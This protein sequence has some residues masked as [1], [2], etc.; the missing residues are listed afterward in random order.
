MLEFQKNIL[1]FSCLISFCLFSNSAFSTDPYESPY[2]QTTF[3]GI[4]L[5]QMPTARSS[6]EGE[7]LFGFSSEEPYNR[8]FSK[9]QVFPWLEAVVRY[10]EGEFKPYNLGINDQTWKDKGIDFKIRLY[11]EKGIWPELALGITDFGGTGAFASEYIVASKRKSNIDFTLGLGWGRFGGV[12]HLTNFIGYIDDSRKKRGGN[13]F[14]GGTL[15]IERLFSGEQVSVFGGIEYFTPLRNLSL[16]LE[17]DTSNY[18]KIIGVE[19][20]IF[21]KGNTFE[22]DS[23][24]NFAIN[25]RLEPSDR[26][27]IDVSLGL[28]HGNTLYANFAVHSNLNF[29]GS[30]KITL[31][32]EK[33]RNTNLPA[34][35]YQELDS[36]RQKFLTNRIIK[37]MANSGFVTHKVIFRKSELAAEISQSRFLDTVDYIDLASRILANN[38]LENIKTITIINIDQG[39]ETMRSSVSRDEL[40]KVVLQG[41]MPEDIV[42][43]NNFS[44][45]SDEDLIVENEYLYPNFFWELRP[46]MLGTLQHQ[47]QFYFWQLQALLH[48]EYSFRKG[49]Y[50]RTDIGINIANNYENYT[51]HYPDGELYHVRQNRRLYLTEGESGIRKMAID[52]MIDI[53]PNIKARLTA[54]YLEWMYGG[55]GG[56]VLFMPDEKK[57]AIGLDLYAVKQREYDQRFSFRDYKTVTGLISYYQDIPF[58][59]MRLKLSAGRFLAEDK[60]VHIDISRRFDTGA[61]VGGIVAL[62]D[63]DSACVGEGSFNKWIYFELPMD[64]FYVSSSTRQKTGYAWSPLTKDAGQRVESGGLYSLMMSSTDETPSLRTKNW[65]AKKILSGFS[66]KPKTAL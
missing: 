59:N 52:Y 26:D 20:N 49:L 28:N 60:G 43:F 36:N 12:D 66:R 62:T 7:F 9:V 33:L 19:K 25:Y 45:I 50:L 54:G 32:A 13:E 48:T 18:S 29:R 22:L 53:N 51:Y 46:S 15:N 41:P 38:A 47:E 37:E 64:I 34:S 11:Q 30:P 65:S 63:C 3:G 58:Y 2:S 27:N 42:S 61:R 44:E 55:I 6:N 31:G 23:R 14:L 10:T 57:W 8:M 24:F 39:L 40:K 17:Y 56:E 21:E 35:S 4:G 5:I 16:K 1:M